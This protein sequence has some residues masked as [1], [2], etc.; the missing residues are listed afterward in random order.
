MVAATTSDLAQELLDA[1]IDEVRTLTDAETLLGMRARY[2]DLEIVFVGCEGTVT[3][4]LSCEVAFASTDHRERSPPAAKPAHTVPCKSRAVLRGGRLPQVPGSLWD[5][6]RNAA[7]PRK[8]FALIDCSP[9]S[10]DLNIGY[11]RVRAE[12]FRG[13]LYIGTL[14]KATIF[15]SYGTEYV[16]ACWPKGPHY[17]SDRTGS[18]VGVCTHSLNGF[19]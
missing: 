5:F 4:C 6:G 9:H 16:D 11:G 2:T 19:F 3:H 18:R 1:V 15:Q 14:R 10:R 8:L 13:H 17:G 7:N 12:C